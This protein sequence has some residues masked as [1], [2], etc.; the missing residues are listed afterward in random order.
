MPMSTCL[1]SGELHESVT[2]LLRHKIF[3]QVT[4]C[5]VSIAVHTWQDARQDSCVHANLNACTG[6]SDVLRVS[7]SMI[8]ISRDGAQD[9]KFPDIQQFHIPSDESLEQGRN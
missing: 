1:Y 9:A 5:K 6:V 4:L 8:S 2:C 3:S 7:Y